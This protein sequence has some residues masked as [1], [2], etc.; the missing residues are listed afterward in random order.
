[1]SVEPVTSVSLAVTAP[2][3]TLCSWPET[4][5]TSSK[6]GTDLTVI[7]PSNQPAVVTDT[8][9]ERMQ[10]TAGTSTRPPAPLYSQV[11]VRLLPTTTAAYSATGA[12]ARERPD[13]KQ[14]DVPGGPDTAD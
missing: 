4:D 6:S 8:A 5:A 11:V 12:P 7:V 9:F 13:K 3:L 1:M 14:R 10:K 2:Q